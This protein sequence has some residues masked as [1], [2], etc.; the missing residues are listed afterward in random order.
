MYLQITKKCN[1]HCEHCC[2]RCTMDGQHMT[3]RVWR[4]AIEFAKDFD[5]SV[6][7]GGGEPTLHPQFWE[8]L[9][10]CIGSFEYVW[11]ATNGSQT[12]TS[13][14][15]ANLAKKGAI[16]C[17]L[18]QDDWHDPID[19]R[20]VNA[21]TENAFEN[22]NDYRHIR[23]VGDFTEDLAPW[24]NPKD[25]GNKENC[26]CSEP[27][28]QTNGKI[29][30]CGCL[31]A[32]IVGDVF[33]GFSITTENEEGDNVLCLGECWKEHRDFLLEQDLKLPK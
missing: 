25:G 8:I 19:Q 4:K 27:V 12:D 22:K 6:S 18:S 23:N 30:F 5:S 16:G 26:P 7:I 3:R 17:D 32:P 13:L 1:F 29:R 2:Y 21:F 11:L 20:V 10:L 14:A 33:K 24:R 31:D 9:G 28:I 15:L